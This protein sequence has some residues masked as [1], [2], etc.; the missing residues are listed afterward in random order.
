MT[1]WRHSKGYI[2]EK[3]VK[4]GEDQ[5]GADA[6][7]SSCAIHTYEAFVNIDVHLGIFNLYLLPFW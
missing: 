6:C 3:L 1:G 5:L 4:Q 7:I 2:I